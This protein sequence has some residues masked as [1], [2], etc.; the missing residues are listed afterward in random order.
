MSACQSSCQSV[1]LSAYTYLKFPCLFEILFISSVIVS[2]V[3]TFTIKDT[4]NRNTTTP[5]PIKIPLDCE[6]CSQVSVGG[7][8]LPPD[9]VSDNV[10]VAD[11]LKL[12][13]NDIPPLLVVAEVPVVIEEVAETNV[14]LEIIG[15]MNR[16][17][18]VT[19]IYLPRWQ[20][21]I[22]WIYYFYSRVCNLL[23]H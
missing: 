9:G 17:V 4:A 11:E 21:L 7:V 23:V 8:A 18:K 15:S 10:R 13:G 3:T 20:L 12:V 22:I 16:I 19:V 6:P 14:Q 5:S 2:T 1:S